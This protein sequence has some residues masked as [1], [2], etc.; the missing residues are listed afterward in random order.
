[1]TQGDIGFVLGGA[2]LQ[3][4]PYGIAAQS[5][6]RIL[7][8]LTLR[9]MSKRLGKIVEQTLALRTTPIVI[10]GDC[11]ILLGCLIGAHAFGRCG[12]IHIDGHSDF[13]HPGNYDT[14]ARLGTAAGMDLALA[15]GRGEPL[16]TRWDAGPSPLVAD[17]DV[18]QIGERDE[19]RPDYGY[20]DIRGTAIRRMTIERALRIGVPVVGRDAVAFAHQRGLKRMWLHVDLDVL[21]ETTMP[22]V[23]SP[24]TPGFDF[25]QLTQLVRGLVERL[26]VIGVSIASFDPDLDPSGAIAARAVD[27]LAAGLEPLGE[28]R[29]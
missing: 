6:T 22:A 28:S 25:D 14:A 26:P 18:M 23:D 12:L 4:P 16:L 3:R 19:R 20:P 24:G 9:Q 7:N 13:F 15:T 1:M 27:F 29:T 2:V 5:G 21:N 17:A 10:G 11:S 8:G